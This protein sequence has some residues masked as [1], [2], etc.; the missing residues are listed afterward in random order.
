MN[1]CAKCHVETKETYVCEHTNH[2]AMCIVCYQEIHW[3]LTNWHVCTNSFPGDFSPD[4]LLYDRY[5]IA[6]F[7]RAS[8]S[9]L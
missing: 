2:R 1:Q 6:W 4:L 9:T 5:F 8:I 3:N 7:F